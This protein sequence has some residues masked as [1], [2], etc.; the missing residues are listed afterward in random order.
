MDSAF[1]KYWFYG[2][3]AVIVF[4]AFLSSCNH[5]N[6]KPDN[7]DA[8]VNFSAN[9]TLVQLE[10]EERVKALF[11]TIPDHTEVS[12]AAKGRMS[13]EL[14]NALH[15]AWEA[16]PDDLDGIG[17]EEF[18]F[19]FLTGN[20]GEFV[21]YSSVKLITDNSISDTER[22]VEVGYNTLWEEG[23]IAEEKS[24]KMHL[25]LER[26]ELVLDDFDGVKEMCLDYIK[27]QGK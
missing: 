4:V 19:Y 8:S 17:D 11:E 23:E 7:T 21:D 10:F 25:K 9:D 20:G 1:P 3:A 5:N 26:N 15:D 27:E 22:V 6:A 12:P 18:L 24:I 16:I 13:E 2:A 14:Y